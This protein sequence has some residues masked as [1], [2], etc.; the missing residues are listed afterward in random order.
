MAVG[1]AGAWCSDTIQ[2]PSRLCVSVH[3]PCTLIPALSVDVSD[4]GKASTCTRR[5]RHRAR[6]PIQTLAGCLTYS[7]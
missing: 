3:P 6:E 5:N 4:L 2:I 1:V 7:G